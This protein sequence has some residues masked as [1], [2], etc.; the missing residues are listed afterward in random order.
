MVTDTTY[1]ECFVSRSDLARTIIIIDDW[2]IKNKVACSE[3]WWVSTRF[4]V[5]L[6]SYPEPPIIKRGLYNLTPELWEELVSLLKSMNFL[7]TYKVYTQ[8]VTAMST[9]SGKDNA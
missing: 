1:V 3:V 5:P 9:W 6:L 4:P 7:K 8:S 2:I